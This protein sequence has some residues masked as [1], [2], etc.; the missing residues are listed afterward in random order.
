MWLSN[1][2]SLRHGRHGVENSEVHEA[3][4]P[5]APFLVSKEVDEE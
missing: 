5:S 3:C 4:P 1:F 2:S